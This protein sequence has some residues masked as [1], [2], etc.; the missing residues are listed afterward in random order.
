MHFVTKWLKAPT[1]SDV[2]QHRSFEEQRK[3][4]RILIIDDDPNAFPVE[5]LQKE[6][7]N[8]THWFKVENYKPL[9][10]GEYDIVVLDI[11]GILPENKSNEDGIDLLRHIKTYNP[12]QIVIAYSGK[13]HDLNKS[14]FWKL[15]DDYLGKPSSIMICKQKID[16]LLTSRFSIDYYWSVIK[17]LLQSQEV[18]EKDIS[19]LETRMAKSLKKKK[20]LTKDDISETIKLSRESLAAV[21]LVVGL[22]TRLYSTP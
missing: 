7:Y 15:A 13:K 11:Q 10:S 8:L 9:E 17:N 19:K 14:D 16:E 3:R 6:G 18:S 5:L 12:A 4:A 22:I 2:A 20:P 1:I 21:S